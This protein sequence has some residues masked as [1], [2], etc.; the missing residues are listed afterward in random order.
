MVSDLI[1]GLKNCLTLD[2]FL[3]CLCMRIIHIPFVLFHLLLIPYS[4]KIVHAAPAEPKGS[5]F[6]LVVN[7]QKEDGGFHSLLRGRIM[8]LFHQIMDFLFIMQISPILVVLIFGFF[9]VGH[10]YGRR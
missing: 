6:S 8:V 10:P 4:R 7:W 3:F 9:H 2:V 5:S 1:H